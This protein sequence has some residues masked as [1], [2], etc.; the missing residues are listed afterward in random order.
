MR[1]LNKSIFFL[2]IVNLIINNVYAFEQNNLSISQSSRF[3]IKSD[4]VACDGEFKS[5]EY[6]VNLAKEYIVLDRLPISTSFSLRHIQINNT[7]GIDLPSSLETKNIYTRFYMPIPFI[8]FNKIYFGLDFSPGFST[9]SGHGLES[10]V[11][12][13]NYGTSIIYRNEKKLLIVAG[14]MFRPQYDISVVPFIGFK[15]KVNNQLD[16][17]FLSLNPN[18]SYK[19]NDKSRVLLEFKILADEFKITKGNR[20]DQVLSAY[21]FDAGIGYE[22]DLNES[23]SAKLSIGGSFDRKFEYMDNDI[24]RDKLKPNDSLYIGYELEKKF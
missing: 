3:A 4:I 10:N 8:D 19:L 13:F 18:I 5:S 6:S 9:A 20:K 21:G 15:Y 23:F 7:S 1:L 17:N 12:N 24:K 14:T 16:L 11:F 22:Y 2:V